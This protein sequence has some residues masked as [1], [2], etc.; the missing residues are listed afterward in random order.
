MRSAFKLFIISLLFVFSSAFAD[1]DKITFDLSVMNG[2]QNEVIISS[3]LE[4][5]AIV[6]EF[7]ANFCGYCHRN[8][9]N[10]ENLAKKYKSDKNVLFLDVAI[11]KTQ[12]QVYKW[13]ARHP[14]EHKL[15]WDENKELWD[16]IDQEYIP[17]VVILNKCHEVVYENSGLWNA[18]IKSEIEATI[19][20][21][22]SDDYKCNK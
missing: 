20:T 4:Q 1:E 13:I 9:N 11:D 7:M 16:Q 6:L 14:S 12:S 19:K 15:V 2:I 21:I 22:S 8:A 18:T 17:A 10:V 3:K 5:R